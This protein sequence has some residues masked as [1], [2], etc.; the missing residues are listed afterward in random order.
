[1][2]CKAISIRII[3]K[4]CFF[5]VLLF[6]LFKIWRMELKRNEKWSC[7]SVNFL[8]FGSSVFFHISVNNNAWIY[9][10]FPLFK[11]NNYYVL[12][13]GSC[14]NFS[15]DLTNLK[16]LWNH[17][18]FSSFQDQI[19]NQVEVSCRSSGSSI[20]VEISGTEIRVQIE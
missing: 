14:G 9:L 2:C 20:R 18:T 13:F 3:I 10:Y 19:A 6:C 4:E 7:K 11:K 15:Q 1:M 12:T 17:L 16:L 8:T 5:S